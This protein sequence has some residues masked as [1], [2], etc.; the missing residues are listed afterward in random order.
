MDEVGRSN[1]VIRASRLVTPLFLA[2]VAAFGAV[3]SMA[4]WNTYICLRLRPDV[5]TVLINVSFWIVPVSVLLA[6]T[7]RPWRSLATGTGLTFVFQRLH[8]L[9][10]KY[11]FA[12]WTAADFRMVSDVANWVLVEQYP[13]LLTFAIGC[14]A[15]LMAIWLLTPRGA[16]VKARWRGGAALLA[17]ALVGGVVSLRDLHPFDPF[18]FNVYGH[19]ASLVYSVPTLEYQAPTIAVDSSH[20]LARAA[21]LP[22]VEVHR[23]PAKP[24]IVIWLQESTMDL[25]LIDVPQAQLPV[26]R[27]YQPDGA[28]REHGLMRVHAWG[29]S[30]WLSEFALLTGL[31][32][33]DFGPSAAS[34]YY[35]VTPRVRFTLPKL[36]KSL[37]YRSI[38]ISGSPKGIY[39]MEQAQRDLGF[40][41]ILNPLDFPEWGGKSLASHYISDTELGQFAMQILQRRHDQPTLVFVLSIM[42]HGPYRPDHTVAYGLERTTLDRGTAARLS[43]FAARMVDTSEACV[44]FGDAL[45]ARPRP[46]VFAYFGDHHPNLE[47]AVPLRQDLEAPRY[48]TSYALKTNYDT[49][50]LAGAPLLDLSYLAAVILQHAGIPLDPYFTANRGMR[51]LCQGRLADCGDRPLRESY[52]AYLYADLGAAERLR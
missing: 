36:L 7:G 42:Q 51:L 31:P 16:M 22:P 26:L 6:L 2:R 15:F 21:M 19:F 30:T 10:W 18:G 34:V 45:L 52:R 40:D 5:G 23:G 39:N 46:V 24:D 41:E 38:A 20:F 13:E 9:K 8:W 17:M 35:T 49:A 3:V 29:G 43:D 37:G 48:T 32:A 50:S 27:M 14:I 44:R 25:A 11:L 4:A 12:S 28:T 1:I 33:E 47:G